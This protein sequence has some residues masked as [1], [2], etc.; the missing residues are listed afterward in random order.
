MNLCCS[1]NADFASVKAFD[2]HRIGKHAYT[3]REGLNQSPSRDDGRR[4]MDADEMAAAG[5]KLNRRFRWAI[6]ADGARI[7]RWAQAA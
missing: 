4:C 3:H 2:N 7:A 5:M 1:C 6:V